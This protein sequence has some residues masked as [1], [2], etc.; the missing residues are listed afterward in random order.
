MAL[1]VLSKT[2]ILNQLDSGYHWTGSTITYSVP[3]SV[4]SMTGSYEKTSFTALSAQQ[5]SAFQLAISLWSDVIAKP[6]VNAGTGRANIT[7]GNFNDSTGSDYAHTYF[8]TWG[9]VWFNTFFNGVN[10]GKTND[11]VH[12]TVGLHGFATYIHELGHGFGLDHAGN[13]NA[14]NGTPAPGSYQDS[15]VYSIMSYF[16]PS[17]GDGTDSRTHVKYSQEVAWGSWGGYDAQ[18]PMLNDVM[19]MQNMYGVSTTTRTGNTTYGYHSNVT[20]G[21]ASIYNFDTNTH[22]V[23]CIF[24][25][26]GIDT[27]D[28][29]GDAHNDQ[30]NLNSGAF[31]NVMGLTNNLSIAYSC[32]IENAT[33][34]SGNDTIT[35]NAEANKLLGGAGNDIISGGA[36]ADNMDGGSGINTLDYSSSAAGVNIN[37]ATLKASGGDATGD[38]FLNFQNVTGSLTGADTL[39]G[40]GAANTLSGGNGN[41]FLQGGGGD[42]KLTGGA[43]ADMFQFLTGDGGRDEI[44]DFKIGTDHVQLSKSFA[45]SFAA[46]HFTMSGDSAVLTMGNETIVFDHIAMNQ[47]HASDFIFV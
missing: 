10:Y 35:G 45:A 28:L 29:S 47:L 34:G 3:T 16:G 43:G 12:P 5:T 17:M 6:V 19:T 18:T 20:G 11:L 39:V 41:D 37:L 23:M 15:T 27:L 33:G 9:S 22:P 46:L 32:T 7:V 42:D 14:G 30:I 21:A 1:P 4:S 2:Q 13:Y 40:N 24:D 38:T 8:P 25:S 44:T 26:S 31:S 36:G